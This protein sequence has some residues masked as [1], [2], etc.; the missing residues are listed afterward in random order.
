MHRTDLAL[1]G[2]WIDDRDAD[3]F[4]AIAT[5]HAAMVFNTCRRI[6]R[7]AAEAEDVAQECF[8]DLARTRRPPSRSLAGWLHRVATCKAVNRVKAE[9]RRRMREHRYAAEQNTAEDIQWDDVYTHLDEAL[10]SLPEKLRTPL[11]HRAEVFPLVTERGQIDRSVDAPVTRLL[12]A[13]EK[14][15]FLALPL[16]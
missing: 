9:R 4:K 13:G 6:V 10:D 8:E 5:R 2:R 3:A 1:L 15:H 12:D 11:V 14:P 16:G 7:D